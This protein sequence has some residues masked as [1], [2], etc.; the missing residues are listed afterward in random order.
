MQGSLRQ[1]I[2][3][4]NAVAGANSMRFVPVGNPNVTPGGLGGGD[5]FWRITLT[6]ALP[7]ITDASTVIDGTAYSFIDGTTLRDTNTGTVGYTGRVGL[8]A[9]V[10]ENTADDLTLAGVARAELEI[11]DGA[12][13]G[14]G[15]NLG[16]TATGSAVRDLAIYG[17]GSGATTATSTSPRATPSS[18]AT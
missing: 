4:A 5:D 18:S 8:G 6:V 9:D 2:Q 3:N 16:A 11:V 12:F 10:V 1:F 13:L 15:L 17:F 14:I 7:A